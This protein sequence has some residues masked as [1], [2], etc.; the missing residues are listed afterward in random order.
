MMRAT[1]GL[2]HHE[3][4]S[5]LSLLAR[6]GPQLMVFLA[7]FAGAL[8]RSVAEEASTEAGDRGRVL[9]EGVSEEGRSLRERPDMVEDD[10]DDGIDGA[11]RGDGECERKVSRFV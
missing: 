5:H 6:H 3:Y 10:G 7:R 11:G 1:R 2:K 8:R 4:L 9:V